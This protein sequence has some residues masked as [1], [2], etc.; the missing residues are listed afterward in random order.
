[1]EENTNKPQSGKEE[2]KPKLVFDD[3][4][5][6]NDGERIPIHEPLKL[7]RYRT[8]KKNTALGWWSAIVLLEDHGQVQ[9]CF[10]RW[11]KRK[12]E[13]KRDKKLAFRAYTDWQDF[14]NTIENFWENLK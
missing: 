14:R 12:G 6:I 2:Q 11:K 8:L 13:W 3:N 1:M 4:E 10:Y 5:H 7:L 9:V